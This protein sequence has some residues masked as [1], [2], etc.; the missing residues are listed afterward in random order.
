MFELEGGDRI[1]TAVLLIRL[2]DMEER[3]WATYGR[4]ETKLTGHQ[5]G[6]LLRQFD[7]RSRQMKFK[8][9]DEMVNRQG[10]EKSQFI[11]L[12]AQYPKQ[13]PTPL[14]S[15]ETLGISREQP[16]YGEEPS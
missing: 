15:A 6:A 12:L 3:L 9:E 4:S 14:P 2:H 1:T 16:I 8:I 7:V 13:S 10:Y 5:L 11:H